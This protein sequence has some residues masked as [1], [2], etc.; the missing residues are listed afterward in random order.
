MQVPKFTLSPRVGGIRTKQHSGII[1]VA[2]AK[3]ALGFTQLGML[4]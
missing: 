2:L 4:I 3:F 1:M